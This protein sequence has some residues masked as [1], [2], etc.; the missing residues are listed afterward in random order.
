MILRLVENHFLWDGMALQLETADLKGSS[1]LALKENVP[2]L[3]FLL[4][5]GLSVEW[6]N[7]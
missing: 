5:W 4:K 1:T 6:S 3:L 2:S 7:Y